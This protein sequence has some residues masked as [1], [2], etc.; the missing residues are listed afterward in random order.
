MT[1]RHILINWRTLVKQGMG[2]T[3]VQNSCLIALVVSMGIFTSCASYHLGTS[4]DPGFKTIFIENFKS[5]VDEPNLENL[6]STTVIQ[7]FQ[8]DGTLQVTDRSKAEVIL[9]G[10]ITEF[11]MSPI[12]YSRANELTPVESSMSIGV[13]YTLTKRDSTQP[14]F[15]GQASGG[16]TFFIGSDLQS[17]KRQGIPLAAEKLGRNILAS[18]V[19]R[20]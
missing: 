10:Q 14:Y 19:D 16:T 5:D 20:W 15:K 4:S 3:I 6:V 9:Q 1:F 2:S 13:R 11:E 7:Q 12:R 18:I 8:N 17:D